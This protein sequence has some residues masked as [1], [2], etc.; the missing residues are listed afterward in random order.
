MDLIKIAENAFLGEPKE[1][2]SFHAGDTVTVRYKIVE[3]AKERI[4]NYKGTVIQ[5]KVPVQPKHSPFARCPEILV[6]KEFSPSS[7]LSLMA[8]K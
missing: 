2:P 7:P 8:S 4:Q 3:G 1:L 5:I 6:W